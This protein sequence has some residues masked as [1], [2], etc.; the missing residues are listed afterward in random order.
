M[1]KKDT[2]INSRNNIKTDREYTK[3]PHVTAK[4]ITQ[5]QNKMYK[6]Q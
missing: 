5:P 4:N 1:I 3:V 6:P 2:Y